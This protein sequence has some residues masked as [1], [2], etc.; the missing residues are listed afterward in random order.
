MK[1]CFT[2]M[3]I[4]AGAFSAALAVAAPAPPVALRV[5][6]PL[7]L[8]DCSPV[9]TTPCFTMSISPVDE[10]GNPAGVLL[11]PQDR[12]LKA[13]SI[14][15][16][17]GMLSPFYVKASAGEAAIARPNIVLIEMDISGSMNKEVSP[18]V[19]RF[20]AARQAIA[21]YVATMQDGVD[22]VAIVP[23]ESHHVL[24]TLQAAVFASKKEQVLAQLKAL[25]DPGLKNNTALYQAVFTGVDVLNSELARLEKSG[26]VRTNVTPQLIV[27]TDGKNEVFPG[28]DSSLLDGPLGLEQ[29]S[30]KVRVAGFDVVGIGFGN[31]S[32]IDAVALRQLSTRFFLASDPLQLAK[33]FQSSTPVHPSTL[34]LAFLALGSDRQSL[35]AQNSQFAVTLHLLD[36]RNLVSPQVEFLPPA[37]AVPLYSGHISYEALQALSAFQPPAI[38]GWSTVL[39]GL[40]VFAGLSVV[41]LLL[42]FWVPRIIWRGNLDGLA[43]QSAQQRWSKE[44]TVQ[45][46]GVQVR[47]APEGFGR[48]V[49]SEMP[50][51]TAAQITQVR[52]RTDL[53]NAASTERR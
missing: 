13:L 26:T 38:S 18:G 44:P 49:S 45:A 17:S 16:P 21:D 28:D 27:M 9:T 19:S 36:G 35:A 47:S 40:L 10:H 34:D 22:E 23:F 3:C 24:P 4:I 32:D 53:S 25:P 29:A 37:M 41:W 50:Q 7:S 46:S 5:T 14:Q 31:P 11:P 48:D 8:K 15:A 39:R 1:L 12:L 52:L 43:A 2:N 51:R 30:A 33:A 20:V 42:W 6:E